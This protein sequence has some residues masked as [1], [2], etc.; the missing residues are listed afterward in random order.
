MSFLHERPHAAP[1]TRMRLGHD[2]A[3]AL[4][5]SC[6]ALTACD[7]KDSCVGDCTEGD[8]SQGKAGTTD[9]GTEIDTSSGSGSGSGSDTEGSFTDSMASGGCSAPPPATTGD[10]DEIGETEGL[11][12]GGDGS[13]LIP[14]LVDARVIR[15]SDLASPPAGLDPNGYLLVLSSQPGICADP[16][17]GFDCSDDFEYRLYLG[18]PAGVTADPGQGLDFG[19]EVDLTG[20]I[21]PSD[22]PSWLQVGQT[23][24][25]CELADP[26]EQGILFIDA[27]D[28]ETLELEGYICNYYWRPELGYGL[29]GSFGTASSC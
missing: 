11:G 4:V 15:A 22:I 8:D 16:L 3:A 7:L 18:L 1:P 6:L 29:S 25:C 21:E 19:A 27:F 10:D 2:I 17:G 9:T 5:C 13:Q 24:N 12:C 26:P 14:Q 23:E 20:G 28:P